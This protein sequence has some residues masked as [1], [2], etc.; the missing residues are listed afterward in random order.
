MFVLEL[1]GIQINLQME[2]CTL[3]VYIY[4]YKKVEQDIIVLQMSEC[5]FVRLCK[6]ENT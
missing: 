4:K 1:S 6:N 2:N 5:N 3:N